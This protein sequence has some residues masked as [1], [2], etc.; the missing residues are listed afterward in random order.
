MGFLDFLSDEP[1]KAGERHLAEGDV[2]KAV[3]A[4]FKAGDHRRAFQIAVEGKQGSLATQVAL[5]MVLGKVPPEYA[6]ATPAQAAELLFS[7][8]HYHEALALFELAEAWKRAAETAAKLQLLPRAARL[9]EK[10]RLYPLAAT[11]YRRSEQLTDTLRMLERESSR[12]RTDPR[13]RR[14]STALE[15]ARK[16]DQERAELLRR[17]G[18]SE[19]AAALI[20]TAPPTAQG[21]AILESGGRI[22]DAIQAHIRVADFESALALLPKARLEPAVRAE[23]LIACRKPLEAATAYVQAGELASAARAA[24]SGGDLERA[25]RLWEQQQKPAEAAAAYRRARKWENAAR[26][27]VAA[28]DM[29]AAAEAFRE[30]GDSQR[31][32][33]AYMQAGHALDAAA[34]FLECGD[35]AGA[36]RA[37]RQIAG[38]TPEA[39]SAT[40]TLARLLY[41]EGEFEDGLLRLEMLPSPI[42]ETMIEAD[43]LLWQGRFLERLERRTDAML[44]YRK[45]LVL[46]PSDPIATTRHAAL[47]AEGTRSDSQASLNTSRS[48][49]SDGASGAAEPEKQALPASRAIRKLPAHHVDKPLRRWRPTTNRRSSPNRPRRTLARARRVGDRHHRGQSLRGAERTRSRRHGTRLPRP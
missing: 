18:R 49:G 27:A 4:F 33:F 14:E 43:R 29:V 25:G 30:S 13:A 26:C 17:M 1:A 39:A 19:E 35:R 12:L 8:T 20:R 48:A 42:A 32:G 16:V 23:I 6:D 31:A 24:E 21:M 36:I 11:Y 40:L 45:V 2:G 22:E 15:G 10:A 44:L 41:E 28:G 7:T 38:G 46:R 47:K 9:Y 3:A 34:C 5:H 37:L